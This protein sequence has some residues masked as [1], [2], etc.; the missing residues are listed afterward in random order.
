MRQETL[1][2]LAKLTPALAVK[3]VLVAKLH[4]CCLRSM[5]QTAAW[6]GEAPSVANEFGQ[7]LSDPSVLK[8]LI[9]HHR[10]LVTLS[11]GEF[12]YPEVG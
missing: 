7:H 4:L 2:I 6:L 1:V 10:H 12:S 11:A 8:T 9:L 5:S 3:G